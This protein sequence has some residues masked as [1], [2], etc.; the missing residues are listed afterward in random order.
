M[1]CF[2]FK[3]A[4]SKKLEWW[5]SIESEYSVKSD[6]AHLITN[7]TPEFSDL[8]TALLGTNKA[9]LMLAEQ[10][11]KF[12]VSCFTFFKFLLTQKTISEL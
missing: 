12:T 10:T 4:D 9:F 11:G 7:S 6:Y 3:M 1:T 8:P 5:V 2:H